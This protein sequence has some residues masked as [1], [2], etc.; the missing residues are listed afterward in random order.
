M[1]LIIH[2]IRY[3]KEEEQKTNK[4]EK[5]KILKKANQAKIVKMAEE[6][7]KDNSEKGNVT[8]KDNKII[9]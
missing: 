2:L 8:D 4:T 7:A 1:N 9:K 3:Q 5:E 6:K